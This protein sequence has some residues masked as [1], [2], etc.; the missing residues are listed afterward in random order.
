MPASR[1]ELLSWQFEL[2]WSLLEL[3]LDE[4]EPADFGWEPARHHWTM[5][6]GPEQTWVPDWSD[7]EPSPIPV[8]TLG[9]V[10]WHLG[11]W[12]SVT[13]DH[14]NG[15]TPREREE[16]SWPGPGQPTI[17]WLRGLRDEWTAALARLTDADLDAPAPFPWPDDPEKTVAHMIAW[18]NA[19]LMKNTAELG[20]LR[21][22]RAAA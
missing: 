2:T 13:L 10:T 6:P 19:E 8:P 18:V 22:L 16:I 14:V 4:L 3:H 9:W 20:Q 21:L 5:R 15:R 11:W 12:W 7:G 17:D 1:T